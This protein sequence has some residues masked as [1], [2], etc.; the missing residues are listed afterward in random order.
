MGGP[1][2]PGWRIR[3]RLR[4]NGAGNTDFLI[5]SY[6]SSTGALL[7]EDQ[8]DRAGGN[9]F[10]NDVAVRG[11][12]LLVAGRVTSGSGNHDYL[13]RAY[14]L[15]SGNLVWEDQLD[16]FGTNDFANGVAV[17]GGRA[18]VVGIALNPVGNFALPNFVILV[19]AYD[20]STGT[21]LWNDQFDLAGG[22]DQGFAIAAE[23]SAVAIT[24][25]GQSVNGDFDFLV[26]TY[27]AIT[28]TLLWQ[29]QFDQASGDDAGISLAMGSG[30]V[31]ASGVAGA[32][33]TCD[34]FANTGD[35]DFAVRAYDAT[36]GTL[37]W[38]ERL[39][40]AGDFDISF[41]IA[42][43][44]GRAFAVGMGTNAAGNGDLL[45][46]AY[47]A[48]TGMLHW[49]DQ[50][51]TVGGNDFV[52]AVALNNNHVFVSGHQASD[53]SCGLF[54]GGNC[55]FAVRAYDARNGAL[56][57]VDQRPTVGGNDLAF[58]IAASGVRVF[59]VGRVTNANGDFDFFVRAY[60][61]R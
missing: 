19:R 46:R 23:G 7:W 22:D 47:D 41:D 48:R 8:V 18:F 27:D 57:W 49:Q 37:L 21:L 35:C 28:G 24:G 17:A 33:S 13:V 40:L 4:H 5:R 20:V 56:A 15:A 45:V 32:D 3:R 34:F 51:D 39:D 6:D 30:L 29:D 10:A 60:D 42:T 25:F 12:D 59:S 61:G 31:L 14:D 55:D 36:T 2:R 9:D 53:A 1:G 16:V 52:S 54:F 38:E 58:A 43:R 11:N 44:G 50:I 26:R